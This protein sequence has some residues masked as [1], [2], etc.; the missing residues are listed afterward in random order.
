MHKCYSFPLCDSDLST[1]ASGGEDQA[2]SLLQISSAR[3]V[4]CLLACVLFSNGGD[5][6]LRVLIQV[7][8]LGMKLL[9]RGKI[10][11]QLKAHE[12]VSVMPA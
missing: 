8:V 4:L 2:A 9:R 10:R 11:T 6:L 12:C 3:S 5:E 7:P 1:E